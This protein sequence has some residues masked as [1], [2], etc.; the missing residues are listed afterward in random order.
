MSSDRKIAA[1]R[2]NAAKSTG[3]KTPAGKAASSRNNLR[4]GLAAATVVLNGESVAHFN[5]LLATLQDELQP[6]TGVESALIE[7]LAI[8]RWR[9]MRLWAFEKAVL[10][11]QM[12]QQDLNPTTSN[13]GTPDRPALD[14]PT[15]TALAFRSLG[16]E[17]R[18]LAILGRHEGRF[19]RQF[20]SAVDSFLEG[21]QKK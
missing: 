9:Q 16:D 14:G 21:R 8:A 17:S 6:E 18:V 20:N 10:T 2:A 19:E 15:R 12:R 3:P 11:N 7:S 5:S 1:N 13:D 4:H